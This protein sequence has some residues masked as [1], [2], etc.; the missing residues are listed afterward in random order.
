MTWQH[1]AAFWFL[2]FVVVTSET[3]VEL[4]ARAIEAVL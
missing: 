4:I 2:M 1:E 3:W